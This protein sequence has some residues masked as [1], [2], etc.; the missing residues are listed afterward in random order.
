M[1]Y[2]KYHK[3]H[4]RRYASYI[5]SPDWI[6]KATN[7]KNTDDACCQYAVTVA[8]NYEEIKWHPERV[9]NIKPFINKYKQKEIN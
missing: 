6:K 3:V 2:Y 7:L 8:L 4:F 5:N 1:M 9:S